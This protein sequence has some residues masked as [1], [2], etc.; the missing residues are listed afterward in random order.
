MCLRVLLVIAYFFLWFV[1]GLTVGGWA[2]QMLSVPKG[3]QI[4]LQETRC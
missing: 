4:S 3:P 2:A 1:I